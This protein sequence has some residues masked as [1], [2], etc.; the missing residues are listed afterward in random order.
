[1]YPNCCCSC[2][3]EP[4]IIKIGQSSHKMYSNNIVNFQESTIILNACTKIVWKPIESTVYVFIWL[5]FLIGLPH[6]D[7]LAWVSFT[8]DSTIFFVLWNVIFLQYFTTRISLSVL[9]ILK[10]LKNM[11][12][13]S[14]PLEL[15]FGGGG[16]NFFPCDM[17]LSGYT[18]HMSDVPCSS[19]NGVHIFHI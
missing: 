8:W 11:G 12:W 18:F 1:M 14:W 17:G 2:S 9:N 6:R 3:F 16:N 7:K 5:L 19:P 15:F 13:F 10:V 4:E